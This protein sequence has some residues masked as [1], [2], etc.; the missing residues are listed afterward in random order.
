[1]RGRTSTQSES[2]RFASATEW[3]ESGLAGGLADKAKH[4]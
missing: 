3:A 2:G 4:Q 1:M